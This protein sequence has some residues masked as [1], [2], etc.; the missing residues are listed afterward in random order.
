MMAWR[1]ERVANASGILPPPFRAVGDAFASNFENGSELGASFA[2]VIGD[3]L[4]I[5]I[6]GGYADR[7][8]EKPWDENT[9]ACIYSSGKAVLS[10]LVA[11]E[12]SN[13]TLSYDAPIAQYWPE[14]AA[15]GKEKIT[16]AEVL[17]HQGGLC[18]IPDE[19][20]PATWLDWGAI[21]AKLAAMA[22]LWAPGTA[23]GYHPQTVGFIAGELLQRVKG[24]TVGQLVQGFGLEIFCGLRRDQ[25]ARTAF[26]QKPPK[27]PDLGELN[28]FT[29]LAFLSKWSAPA[30]VAHEDWMAAEIP[31]SNM[32]ADARSLAAIVHPFVN[33]GKWNGD[34]YLDQAAINDA[35]KERIRGDDLVLPFHLSWSAGLMRN[36]NR[37]FGPN[38]TAFGHAGFGGSC[39][40]I[41]PQNNLTAAYVMNKM[42]HYLVGD[43]RAV[44]LLDAVYEAL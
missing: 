14:F 44:R 42:S 13:G 32:H 29:K 27:P 10:L 9:L 33:G 22:P 15:A 36:I 30:R 7:G 28:E 17:S 4:V 39:V 21:T 31:A 34:S 5:D 6:R 37:H 16:I 2:A 18:G 19:M 24:K 40:V 35:L 12:V 20:P 11:R 1:D 23:N 3:E 25:M 43:P 8:E 26:M 41:D 38:E